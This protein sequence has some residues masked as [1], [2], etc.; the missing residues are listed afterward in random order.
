MRS[1]AHLHV[2]S[3]YSF[4]RGA[5]SIEEICK[6][7]KQIG[8][9]NLAITDINGIYGLVWFLQA[10]KEYGLNPIISAELQNSLERCV[11]IAK[12][13]KG[14][15]TL[16]RI[17]T[18]KHCEK[19]LD[20]SNSMFQM[21][22]DIV[23]I[24]DSVS[25]L[26]RL[27]QIGCEV[28]AEI[29]PHRNFEKMLQF[30]RESNIPPVATGDAYFIKNEDWKIHQLLR[31]IDLNTTLTRIPDKELASPNAYLK[32][33]GEM[34][35]LFPNCP[36]AIENSFKIAQKCS[37]DLNFGHLIFA[38]FTGPYGEDA[39][40]YLE[41]ESEKG[42]IWRYGK[43]TP[44]VRK[45]LDYELSIISE[46]GFSPYFLVVADIVRHA[47]RTCG[48]GSAAAS[49]VSYCLGIT[50]VD[51][52][53]YDLFFD[54]FLNPGRIDPPDIDVDFP[55]DERDDVLNFIFKKYGK[56]CTAMIA[57]HNGFRSR[58]AVREVAKVFGLADSEISSVT[59]RLSSHWAAGGVQDLIDKHP[60]FKGVKLDSPWPEIFIFAEKLHGFP[61]HLSVHCGGVVIAPDGLDRYVPLQPAKKQ[62]KPTGVIQFDDSEASQTCPKEFAWCNG[63]KTNQRK[64]DWLKWTYLV[65]GL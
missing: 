56:D 53:R 15:A 29:I 43:I 44:K 19:N 32:S 51:P 36:E 27:K 21:H 30:S 55:W 52:I 10:A 18:A 64:W 37:F 47:P 20:L 24:S 41:Q 49:L 8:V 5:N 35:S 11:I 31:A 12:N 63:K 38:S 26:K 39:Y 17:L 59:K 45:R 16:C 61:R 58:S 1:F 7:T 23:V 57:N 9:E 22:N 60:V 2:H 65:I 4:G 34:A 62:L 50:H 33:P 42:A 25:L 13:K 28:Y 54:R 48:R 46:K 6:A 3:N 40:T 14:Y